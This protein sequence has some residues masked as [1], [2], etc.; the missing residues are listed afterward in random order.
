MKAR[1]TYKNGD[2]IVLDD[3]DDF[4]MKAD[5]IKASIRDFKFIV[6]KDAIINIDEIAHIEFFE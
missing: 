5:F 1:I 2:S 4:D 6:N 3:V